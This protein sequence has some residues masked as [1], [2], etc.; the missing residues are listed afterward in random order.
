MVILSMLVATKIV[1]TRETSTLA[2]AIR[3]HN[4]SV[5]EFRTSRDESL[6]L[7]S[8][9]SKVAGNEARIRNTFPSADYIVPFTDALAE[10]AKRAAVT[11][12]AHYS[13]PSPTAATLPPE[14]AGGP[15]STI[16]AI[17]M[18][19]TIDGDAKALE[20]FLRELEAL[21]YYLTLTSLTSTSPSESGWEATQ[22]ATLSATLYT[23][24]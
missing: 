16:Y 3:E 23:K 7:L 10:A 20:Q 11:V 13:N 24:H 1:L 5:Q 22:R 8:S 21:P 18:S 12:D 9:F 14:T 19:M 2:A 6:A 15:V 17:T 4:R